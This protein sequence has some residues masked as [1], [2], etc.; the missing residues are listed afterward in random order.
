M[1]WWFPCCLFLFKHLQNNK[2]NNL[3]VTFSSNVI[4]QYS[5]EIQNGISMNATRADVPMTHFD[6]KRHKSVLHESTG[7]TSLR[8]LGKLCYTVK[9]LL[10]IMW[11]AL[12]H[13][14]GLKACFK[15]QWVS[16][17]KSSLSVDSCTTL[18]SCNM[19]SQSDT[20]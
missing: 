18:N 1:T 19:Y 6:T 5:L 16:L 20:Q 15:W 12:V 14:G 3:A 4:P 7:W 10:P 17:N 8:K 13:F 11:I 9:R 2:N